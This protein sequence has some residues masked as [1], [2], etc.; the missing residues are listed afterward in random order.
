MLEARWG[1]PTIAVVRSDLQALLLATLPDG[2]VRLGAELTGLRQG[3][4]HVELSLAGGEILP[5]DVVIGADGLRSV[6]RRHL[7]GDGPPRYRGYTSWRGVAAEG[8][9]H[10]I[11]AAPPSCGGGAS[12]SGSFR[13]GTIASSGTRARN[14]PEGDRAPAGER[15]ELLR[16]FGTWPHPIPAVLASTS[17][18]GVVRT[19]VYDRPV[20]RRWV[21]SQVASCSATPPTR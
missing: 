9:A 17:D 3:H 12:A 1:A 11:D 8:T 5:A 7:L 13:P 18:D 19:D 6:V 2:A 16:R 20:T 15:H 4:G 21:S 14:A 10:G